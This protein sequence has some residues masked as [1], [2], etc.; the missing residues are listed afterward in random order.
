MIT[1]KLFAAVLLFTI[2]AAG[3]GRR[4]I[5]NTTPEQNAEIARMNA[6]LAPQ[7]QRLARARSDLVAAALAQPRDDAT[8]RAR[9]DAIRDA[10][11]ELANARADAFADVQSSVNKLT[12][13]QVSALAATGAGGRGG[14]Y[15]ASMPHITAK[16]ASALLDMSAALGAQV[17]ALNTARTQLTLAALGARRNDAAIDVKINAIVAAETAL[18]R[19]RADA[20]GRLQAT[21]N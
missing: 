11:L 13:D 14:G 21:A 5:A 18:A 17:Q 4:G 19:A 7:T 16:Q 1:R 3:Q 20:F 9:V 2:A 6:A 12:A 10:E 8:I 15:R